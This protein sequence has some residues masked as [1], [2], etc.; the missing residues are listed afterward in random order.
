MTADLPLGISVL[1]A[2]GS[3]GASTLDVVARH[4]SRFRVCGLAGGRNVEAMRDLCVRFR[5]RVVAMADPQAAR[6][7]KAALATDAAATEVLVGERGVIAVAA[8]EDA[9]TVMS[10]ITGAAGLAPTLSAVRAGKRILLANKESLVMTGAL[11]LAEVARCGATLLPIDSEHNAVFQCLPHTASGVHTRGVAGI[12]LTASGGPF[13][14]W[15]QAALSQ[16]TPEQ[17]LAHPRWSMGAKISIDSAT[18]MNKGLEVIEA[19]FLFGLREDQIEVVVH[20]ES[21]VHSLVR[22]SDGSLLAQLGE[23]D[24]RIPI[25]HALGWPERIDSGAA[26]LDLVA[27]AQL[28]FE[29]P[30]TTAFPALNLAREAM[31]VGGTATAVLNAA[32][33]VA[34]S[35][36]LTRQI[37]F[38]TISEVVDHTLQRTEVR[39]ATCIDTVLE[40]DR[41][42]REFAAA[43]IAHPTVVAT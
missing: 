43:Q 24:M 36:F 19:G 3:I 10:A 34:V 30:D 21:A 23:A 26:S 42:A 15:S 1:G 7:L 16:V 2:T 38:R 14:G 18:L 37:G 17:A 20:P 22:Y 11:L 32:N 6:A 12:V 8:L 35:A 9:D 33:E 28:R 4:P 39:A 40:A 31:R 29:Q 5:P 25:A 13:R 27:L 41:Q